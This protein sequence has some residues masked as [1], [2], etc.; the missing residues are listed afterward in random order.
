MQYSKSIQKHSVLSLFDKYRYLGMEHLLQEFL[1]K[2]FS[3][4]VDFVEN[5]KG[6]ITAGVYLLQTVHSRNCSTN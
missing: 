3:I 2:N 5:K 1:I 6:E 4:N